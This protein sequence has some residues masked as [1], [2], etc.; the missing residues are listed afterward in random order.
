MSAEGAHITVVIYA[1][2]GTARFSHAVGGRAAK[3]RAKFLPGADAVC[4]SHVQTRC[5]G[6]PD[7]HELPAAVFCLA[8]HKHP[9]W[10]PPWDAPDSSLAQY[11]ELLRFDDDCLFRAWIPDV[12]RAAIKLSKRTRTGSSGVTSGS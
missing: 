10:S 4:S 2:P 5:P 3:S 1:W 9:L 11:L 8:Q 6:A 7:W 12:I